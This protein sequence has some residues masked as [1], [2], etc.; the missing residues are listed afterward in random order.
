[1]LWK[2]LHSICNMLAPGRAVS[3]P[4]WSFADRTWS[5]GRL[6]CLRAIPLEVPLLSTAGEK[7]G[8]AGL[9]LGR[10][11][12][13]RKWQPTPVLLPGKSHGSISDSDLRVPEELGQEGKASSCVKECNFT[14]L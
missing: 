5:Q 14:C 12:W 4:V 9:L 7:R 6:R 2:V 3:L 1:M 13:R 11:H 8:V 10:M